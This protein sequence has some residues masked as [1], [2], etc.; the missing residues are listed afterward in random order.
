M[1]KVL[2]FLLSVLKSH[3]R[4][5]TA[6]ASSG[7]FRVHTMIL[8][9]STKMYQD[10]FTSP[11]AC[12]RAYFQLHFFAAIVFGAS[13]AESVN[14]C[15]WTH[16]KL[17]TFQWITIFGFF[18]DCRYDLPCLYPAML[19]CWNRKNDVSTDKASFDLLSSGKFPRKSRIMNKLWRH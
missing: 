12:E 11:L 17:I 16:F 6:F 7:I 10:V 14:P 2:Q 1:R 3:V 15:I 9:R 18:E 8:D 19:S 5:Y 13:R 4:I